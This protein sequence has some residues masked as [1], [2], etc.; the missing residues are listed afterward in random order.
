MPYGKAARSRAA[1][2][3]VL[4]LVAFCGSLAAQTEPDR[5]AIDFGRDVLP[6][7]KAHCIDCHGPDQ[8]MNGFRLD[9]RSDAMKG[10]TIAVI[11]PGSSAASRLYL[12]LVSDQYGS[13][14]PPDGRLTADEIDAIKRWIDQG[15]KWPDELAGER[16][17][18]VPD[19]QA[20]RLMAAVRQG[21]HGVFERMLHDDPGIARQ[22]GPGG[23]TPL[24]Y[25]VLYADLDAVRRLLEAGAD[26]NRRND[27]GATALMWAVDDLEKTQLL[28]KSGADV[29][30]CSD[31]GRTPLLIAAGRPGANDVVRLLLEHG[32]DPS[33]VAPSYRGP[34]TPL[35]Q[36]A[37]MGD[38]SLIRM[39]LEHKADVRNGGPL[40]WVSAL[41]ASSAGCADLLVK[42]SVPAPRNMGLAFVAPPF[43]N[44]HVLGDAALV[45][46]LIEQGADVNAQDSA[47]RTVLML[48]AALDTLPVETVKTLL[49]HGADLN[50]KAADGKTALDFA[51]QRGQ[52]PIVEVLIRAGAE[53][54]DASVVAVEQPKP[55]ASARAALERSIPLLQR[56]DVT[57]LQ[58]SGCVSCHHNSLAAMTVSMARHHGVPVDERMVGSQLKAIGRYLESWRERVLQDA[59]IPGDV[60]TIGY[61]LM[62]LAAENYPP[63]ATTDALA[64]YIKSRQ[65]SDGGWRMG[66]HRPPIESSRFQVTAACLRSLQVYHPPAKRA[67]YDAAVQRAAAWLKHSRPVTTEDFVFQILGLRWAGGDERTIRAAAREL[68]ARQRDDGGFGP[69]LSMES[70][71]YATGQALVALHEAGISATD[72]AYQRG[73]RYL[74]ETQLEDGSWHV[75]SRALPF[76]P[77]FDS[78]FPHREDQWISAAA[79]NWAAMALISAVQ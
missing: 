6:L 1:G 31:D 45:K 54:G 44:E 12:K 22:Q 2:S 27:A 37:D 17:A 39:L 46:S 40:P 20:A 66:G 7:F 53:P 60:D 41:N 19:P 62:G 74:I 63:D 69:L 77:Q 26:P 21:D 64:R 8:Q 79:T 24:M 72:P 51:R 70:D 56:A 48:A 42:S 11:G 10:G 73:V 3:V 29:H 65:A 52:T 36:A 76:Q 16:A 9:R 71:A 67:E 58:K 32:A 15:A 57:F 55:A 38:E 78:G 14:M 43:G 75:P 5:D 59:A 13:R 50:A 49:A 23:C 61:F 18:T 33:V 35:R 47:G 25:A 68:L 34:I 4:L 28:I 30:A